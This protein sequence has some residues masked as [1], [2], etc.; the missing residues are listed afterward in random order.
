MIQID[1]RLVLTVRRNWRSTRFILDNSIAACKI[2]VMGHLRG[3]TDKELA[4]ETPNELFATMVMLTIQS[5]RC[6]E[7]EPLKISDSG[8]IIGIIERQEFPTSVSN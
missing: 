1:R 5:V 7:I 3:D 8:Q 4:P 6:S 2:D